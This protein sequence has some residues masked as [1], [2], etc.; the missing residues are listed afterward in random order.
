MRPPGPARVPFSLVPSSSAPA[1]ETIFVEHGPFPGSQAIGCGCLLRPREP[2]TSAWSWSSGTSLEDRNDALATSRQLLL[3]GGPIALLL[4][5]AAGY[6][7]I[8]GVPATGR[9]MRRRAAESRPPSAASAYRSRPRTTRSA[10]SGETLNDMLARLEA[11]LNRE[12]SFVADASHELRT[13]LAVMKAEIELGSAQGPV[14][15][16]AGSGAP[17]GRATK[18]DRLVQLAEDLLVI[19]SSD[20]G[21]LPVR[22]T[23]A[24]VGEILTDVRDRF[25]VRS[26]EMNRSLVR[27]PQRTS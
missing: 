26:R 23:P 25:A 21:K 7:A 12:R 19:A 5:S 16:R 6:A 3:I 4:A 22:V 27:G 9:A 2:K 24:K 17:I 11:G 14:R 1:S 20:Q 18:T 15:P 13:P 10:A 8:V